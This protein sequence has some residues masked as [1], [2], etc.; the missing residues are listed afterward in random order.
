MR[1]TTLGLI[2][3][4]LISLSG[5]GSSGR[6]I[7]DLGYCPKAYAPNLALELGK[8]SHLAYQNNQSQLKTELNAMGYRLENI[9]INNKD[10]SVSAFIASKNKRTIVA[11][12]GTDDLEDWKNNAKTWSEPIHDPICNKQIRVHDGFQNTATA[13]YEQN[14]KALLSY[15]KKLTQQGQHIYITGHSLGGALATIVSYQLKITEPSLN[16][17]GIYTYGQPYTGDDDFQ[18]CYD[19]Q[20]K[21]KTFR[22]VDDKDVIPK[23]RLDNSYRHVGHFLFFN[24]NGELMTYKPVNYAGDFLDFVQSDLLDAHSMTQYLKNLEKNKQLNP[25]SCL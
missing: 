4:I 18:G 10:Y 11:F 3:A 9:D 23:A 2:T 12:A 7:K 24:G 14:N 17:V 6:G 13:V 25:F 1:T 22:F 20:L 19:A 8:M 21:N 16:I 5:C 15:L